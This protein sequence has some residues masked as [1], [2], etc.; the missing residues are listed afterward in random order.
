MKQYPIELEDDDT[1]TNMGEE[2]EITSEIAA[3]ARRPYPVL[4]TYEEDSGWVGRVPD[5][6]GVIAVGDT[7]DEMM[8]VLQ[9]AKAV[10][11]A[12]MLRHGETVPAPRSYDAVLNPR[13]GIAAR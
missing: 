5:L 13:G 1:T 6:P 4:V 2:L 8:D 3:L 9:G 12:S 10:Y 7:P 11:I